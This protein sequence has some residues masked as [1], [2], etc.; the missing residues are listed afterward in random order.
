MSKGF[1][2]SLDA[3]LAVLV[4]IIFLS[5]FS[6][7]SAQAEQDNYS[8]ILLNKQANDLLT[9]LDKT[10]EL[11]TLNASYINNS[12][13]STLPSNIYWNIELE[14]YNYTE[15]FEKLGNFSIGYIYSNQN[16][17]AFAQREFLVFTNNSIQYFG[18]A[19]L[20]LWNN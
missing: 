7:L 18:I 20:N 15:G 2:F 6:F 3:I 1:V 14:Y 5:T 16:T 19:R 4:L 13:N 8:N 9:V 10:G 17:V 12:I 11:S